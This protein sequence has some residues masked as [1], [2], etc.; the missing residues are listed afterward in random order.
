MSKKQEIN[1]KRRKLCQDIINST[2]KEGQSLLTVRAAFMN[3][4]LC[5][6]VA[7]AWVGQRDAYLVNLKKRTARE[8][9]RDG[10]FLMKRVL[11]PKRV[12][13]PLRP[14]AEGECPA[15]VNPGWKFEHNQFCN[16]LKD[17]PTYDLSYLEGSYAGERDQYFD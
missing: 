8:Y 14:V 1:S 9:V 15:C 16:S 3:G 13:V 4:S 7:L 12:F 11:L 6:G 17:I 10:K 5:H 2:L